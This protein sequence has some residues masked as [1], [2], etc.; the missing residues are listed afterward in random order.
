MDTRDGSAQGVM[1]YALRRP[2]RRNY[3]YNCYLKYSDKI[4][5]TILL[6]IF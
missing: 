1:D 3:D 4:N 2:Y 6:G 5:R